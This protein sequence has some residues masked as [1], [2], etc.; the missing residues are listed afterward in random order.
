[1]QLAR[2]RTTAAALA[3]GALALAGCSSSSGGSALPKPATSN[4]ASAGPVCPLTGL[5]QANGQRANRVA[6]AV[7]VDNIGPARP[8]AGVNNADVV[9]EELVEGGLTRLMVVFQCQRAGTV[10]PIRSARISDAD[11]LALLHGSVLGYSGANPK[12]MPPIRAHSGAALVPYDN[13][14]QYFHLDSA[15][16]APHNVFSST[17]T[18]LQAGLKLRS[19][20]EAP[21]PLFTYGAISTS[22]RPARHITLAWPDSAAR[23]VWSNGTWLRDQGEHTYSM[24][25]DTLSDGQQ[26]SATNV[27]VLGVDIA[28]T[29]L[30]D[31]LG[32]ASPLDVTIGSNPAWVL[33]DGKLIRGTWT[34][35]AIDDE[36]SLT[37]AQGH[38]IALAPGRTW[39]ELLPR[40]GKPTRH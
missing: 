14:P 20:L 23:W 12:D 17:S 21:L 16:P 9:F 32:N 31:V 39:V 7:K 40:P 26:I 37:D 18:L 33:R 36:I 5:P 10:G 30:H 11:L 22:A 35:K 25:P 34:R 1:M 8:Q 15:R 6:L 3:A 24:T 38:A 29:G 13:L 19:N 4:Q 2:T 28:S 27:V